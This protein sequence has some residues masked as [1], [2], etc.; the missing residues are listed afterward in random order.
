MN[1]Q[2]TE[3]SNARAFLSAVFVLARGNREGQSRLA[4]ALDR[5][6]DPMTPEED[7]S[8]R[9]VLSDAARRWAGR[10]LES[11]GFTAFSLAMLQARG[12]DDTERVI[13]EFSHQLPERK[14]TGPFGTDDRAAMS[15]EGAYRSC[16]DPQRTSRASA[17]ALWDGSHAVRDGRRSRPGIPEMDPVEEALSTAREMTGG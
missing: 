2:T 11:A 6:R 7:E 8:Q 13:R 1:Q 15:V 17:R 3:S 9:L 10:A 14:D 16:T 5:A 12:E 4:E